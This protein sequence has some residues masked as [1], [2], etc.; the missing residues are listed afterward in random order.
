M[1]HLHVKGF[2]ED[3]KN[4][5]EYFESA[6]VEKVLEAADGNV[7]RAAKLCGKERRAFGKLVKKYNIIKT[8][9]A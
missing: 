4:A 5:L 9:N 8:V 6:Y 3:K 7:T 2:S 1:G